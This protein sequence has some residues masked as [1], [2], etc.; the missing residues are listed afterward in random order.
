MVDAILWAVWAVAAGLIGVGAPASELSA[1]ATMLSG[2]CF[3]LAAMSVVT[4]I[5]PAENS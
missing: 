1:M 2:L 3:V 4:G 5:A